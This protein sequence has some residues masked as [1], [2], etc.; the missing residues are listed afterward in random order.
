[1]HKKLAKNDSTDKIGATDSV[2]LIMKLS[3]RYVDV[4]Y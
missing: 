1:M 4:I 2:A 3:I